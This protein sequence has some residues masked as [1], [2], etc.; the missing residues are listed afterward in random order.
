[1]PEKIVF[2]MSYKN[3]KNDVTY[4]AFGCKDNV[5]AALRDILTRRSLPYFDTLLSFLRQASVGDS[6]EMRDIR[7]EC[8]PVSEDGIIA[9]DTVIEYYDTE[10]RYEN[11]TVQILRNSHTGEESIGW[12]EN[13]DD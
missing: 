1:M 10:E 13:E 8:V 9:V 5:V 3:P 7:M 11:C 4:V 2:K 12:W 6:I